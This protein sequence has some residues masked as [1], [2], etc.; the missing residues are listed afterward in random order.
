MVHVLFD[1]SDR[2][3]HRISDVSAVIP[4]KVPRYVNV[5]SHVVTTWKGGHKY[6][7]G[8]VSD[9]DSSNRLKVTFDDNDED[10]YTA[11]QLRIFPDHVSA[12]AG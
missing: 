4:D 9:K 3:T 8:Y 6:Y 2:I 1:D 10:Y 12:H 7:I 5:G 11:S